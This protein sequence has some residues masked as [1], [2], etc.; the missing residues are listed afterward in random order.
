[1]IFLGFGAKA[2][3]G[4]SEFVFFELIPFG[5]GEEGMELVWGFKSRWDIP[6]ER[7]YLY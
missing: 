2:L 4:S 5:K 3:M 1:M 7:M 6:R